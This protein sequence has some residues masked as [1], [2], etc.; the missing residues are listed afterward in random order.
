MV[1]PASK[2]LQNYNSRHSTHYSYSPKGRNLGIGVMLP[3][4]MEQNF[5][6]TTISNQMNLMKGK[7]MTLI[8]PTTEEGKELYAQ[9]L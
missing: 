9:R 4:N 3:L 6:N 7:K 5:N 8:N 1:E 2:Y